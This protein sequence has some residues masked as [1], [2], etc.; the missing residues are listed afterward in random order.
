[1]IFVAILSLFAMVSHSADKISLTKSTLDTLQPITFDQLNL[2]GE[3]EN[4]RSQSSRSSSSKSVELN[5]NLITLTDTPIEIL[6]QR[7]RPLDLIKLSTTCLR[8]QEAFGGQSLQ[9]YFATKR[10]KQLRN[11]FRIFRDRVVSESPWRNPRWAFIT[12][13]NDSPADT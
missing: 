9:M 3:H 12:Y 8:Y 2:I 13:D 11:S 5:E 4:E 6:H 10:I 1:M 7:L